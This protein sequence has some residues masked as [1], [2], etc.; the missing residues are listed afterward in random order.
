MSETP[1][2]QNG[3]AVSASYGWYV[4]VVMTLIYLTN[5]GDRYLLAIVV[6][7][8][9][10]EFHLNDTSIGILTGFAFALLYASCGVLV[11][12][13]ADRGNR[14]TIIAASAFI[15]SLMTAACGA[16]QSYTQLALARMGVA[17]GESG[18]TPPGHSLISDLFPSTKRVLPLAVVSLGASIGEWY[19]Y[20]VGSFL[21]NRF[22]WRTPFLI[23]AI[24]GALLALLVRFT[25]REPQ[26][27][28]HDGLASG[29][30]RSAPTF[31]TTLK[32]MW[33]Q[34][35][36]RHVMIASGL[37]N[38]FG[39]SMSLWNVTFMERS[40]GMSVGEAG[41]S[42]G[43]WYAL[44]GG[45]GG[46]VLGGYL[47]QKL[48]E[49]DIRWQ[50]RANALLLF[51][52][53]LPIVCLYLLPLGWRFNLCNVA[54]GVAV[55][56]WMGGTYSMVQNLVAIRMRALASAVLLF[57][58]NIIGLGLGPVTVGLIS[59]YLS[60]HTHV[61]EDALRYALLSTALT[62]PWAGVHFLLA[63]R[64]LKSDYQNAMDYDGS[65]AG[66]MIHATPDV[67]RSFR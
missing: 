36:L 1:P 3:R 18:T 37:I 34:R 51:A 16:A 55:H 20:A 6:E 9:K 61:G 49:I 59:D 66:R 47:A 17:L 63:E 19:G 38:F 25:V 41:N 14:R 30:T 42:F 10:A 7:P 24:P 40:L 31:W 13:F 54:L 2:P 62:V 65:N 5:M 60:R 45:N 27:G 57:S 56:G 8:L 22:G 11:A 28:Q 44:I 64:T 33:S 48:G 39:Y 52:T 32:F 46:I 53:F 35:A 43:L 15:F 4:V 58:I 50:T 26:R 67:A 29:T 23:M 21:A 12:V